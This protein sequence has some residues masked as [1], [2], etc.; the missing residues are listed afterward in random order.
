MAGNSSV[1]DKGIP[2][3][4]I[5]HVEDPLVAWL[6]FESSTIDGEMKPPQLLGFKPEFDRIHHQALFGFT[7]EGLDAFR[8]QSDAACYPN[9]AEYNGAVDG[10]QFYVKDWIVSTDED[11]KSVGLA[12]CFGQSTF[13]L[14]HIRSVELDIDLKLSLSDVIRSFLNHSQHCRFRRLQSGRGIGITICKAGIE[15]SK[16]FINLRDGSRRP[17]SNTDL[18]SNSVVSFSYVDPDL[19]AIKKLPEWTIGRFDTDIEQND[20]LKQ[21]SKSYFV[22]LQARPFSERTDGGAVNF[23]SSLSRYGRQ[24]VLPSETGTSFLRFSIGEIAS[25]LLHWLLLRIFAHD[26]QENGVFINLFDDWR[27]SL[28][29]DDPGHLRLFARLLLAPVVPVLDENVFVE[30]ILSLSNR[31][32]RFGVYD[33]P[34]PFAN[35]LKLVG[36]DSKMESAW[37]FGILDFL[38]KFFSSTDLRRG[39]QDLPM[40]KN[41]GW[42]QS[43]LVLEIDDSSSNESRIEAVVAC[44]S[45][46]SGLSTNEERTI[47]AMAE[48]KRHSERSVFPIADVLAG[49]PRHGKPLT[50]Y[51]IFPLWEETVE[52]LSGREWRG[53]V[54]FAH[55][56]TIAR[57]LRPA[58]QLSDESALEIGEAFQNILLPAGAS[59][60][61]EFYK[62]VLAQTSAWTHARAWAHEVKNYTSP[63]IDDLGG[64]TLEKDKKAL[65]GIALQTLEG[66]RRGVLI[67]NAVS[68]AVQLSLNN[69]VDPTDVKKGDGL[70]PLSAGNGKEIVEMALQYLLNYRLQFLETGTIKKYTIEWSPRLTTDEALTRLSQVLGVSDPPNTI[71]EKDV[72]TDARVIGVIALLREV[73]WN[74]R[75]EAP[76]KIGRA[77]PVINLDYEFRAQHRALSLIIQQQQIETNDGSDKVESSPGIR[78][79]NVLFGP[80]GAGFGRIT[81][82][83]RERPVKR[84]ERQYLVTRKTAVEFHMS[85]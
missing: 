83:Q 6:V 23:A 21:L 81:E 43:S 69:R 76:V 37:T 46:A 5:E 32:E 84:A 38:K 22:P 59:I 55:V 13:T 58:E 36:L 8:N 41:L 31:Q 15:L 16:T 52:D 63:I 35:L 39:F 40:Y 62:R 3:I 80:K 50:Y 1:L 33:S 51:Y 30:T 85:C 49:L 11:S 60:A 25:Y 56:F 34:V 42:Q 53:P 73:V 45:K 75:N 54:I 4:P 61:H 14:Q 27:R 64:P 44:L 66:S 71:T 2:P 17:N 74:I 70:I 10:A 77:L 26:C 47:N 7:R 78:F 65:S 72:V 57:G 20:G 67:L 48:L 24:S 18:L 19:L 82:M 29:N 79:A 68:K 28:E 9:Y 12:E